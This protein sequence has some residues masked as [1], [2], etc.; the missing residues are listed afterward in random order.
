MKTVPQFA[1]LSI[2]LT[3][4]LFTTGLAS[5]SAPR[6]P[7]ASASDFLSQYQKTKSLEKEN[8]ASSCQSYIRLSKEKFPLQNLSLLK[9]HLHCPAGKDL[10]K[11][12][13]DLISREPWL[14]T[15][16][17]E[18]QL[19]ETSRDQDWA[20]LMRAQFRKSQ[21]QP[22]VRDKVQW[23]QFALKSSQKIQKP[24]ASE[25]E[26]ISEIQTRL[27]RFAP[28]LI[29]NPQ[30]KDYFNVGV[31][32]ISQR[33]FNKGRSYL[34]K[35]FASTKSSLEEQFLARRA[36]RNSFKVE[37][38][39]KEHLTEAGRFADWTS[40]KMSPARVQEAYVTWA[41][42]QWTQGQVAAAR[43]TLQKAEQVLE[44][45]RHGFDEI[46]F[47]RAKMQEEA[48]QFDE[49]LA[50]L[51]QAEKEAVSSPAIRDRILFSKAWLLRKQG[52]FLQASEA[53]QK[54]K[55]ETQDPFDKNRF[56]FWLAK[57]LKQAKKLPESQRELAELTANDPLGYY[58]L[59][60]YRELGQEIP[61]LQASRR[62]ASA[63]PTVDIPVAPADHDLIEALAQ[64]EEFEILEKFL[65][66][67]TSQLRAQKN[68]NPETWFYFLKGYAR[69]G[70]YNPLFA[71]IGTLSSDLK[72]KLLTSNPE[73]LFPRR[74]LNLIDASAQKFSVRPELVLSI[75]RQESAFN[76]QARSG[77]DAF[78]LMQILPSVAKRKQA[79]TGLKI[80][81]FE[82]LHSPEMNIPFGTALLADLNHKY[83]G[84]FLLVAAAYNANEKA[85]STWLKTRLHDDPLEFIEDIPYEETKAYVKLVLRNFIFYSRLNNPTQSL[86]FPN[87]CLEDLHSF[88]VSTK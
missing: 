59:V 56:S 76:P 71:Q 22:E 8:P 69:A 28:R 77:A 37:Q 26:L 82:D 79:K 41:R 73:L 87:W 51:E 20:G 63:E 14:E 64:V 74:Y 78:G 84:Q 48:K 86:E 88:K 11:V 46:Y 47:L 81:H 44:K 58:G 31:D 21:L 55:N 2:F 50:T 35:V 32:W 30:P 65:D 16:D 45:S 15:L 66:F 42:A 61:A 54:L 43:S 52:K 68:S 36:Y 62:L 25:R 5:A 33:E 70:L 39:K 10:E 60:A 1:A 80:Q 27:H 18:R 34:K 49:A 40:K 29:E 23:L 9:S 72:Y 12:P 38:K 13:E 83:R 85:I 24:E 4:L 67:K 17:V 7:K 57:S 75:I 3:S 53:L 19:F 6:R